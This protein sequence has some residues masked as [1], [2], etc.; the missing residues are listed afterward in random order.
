MMALDPT[1]VRLRPT[2]LSRHAPTRSESLAQ[3]AGG[4]LL[5]ASRIRKHAAEAD[6]DELHLHCVREIR[7]FQ[8]RAGRSRLPR[9][10]V[11]AA[12]YALCMV[13]DEAVLGMPWSQ[14]SNWASRSMALTFHGEASC[15]GELARFVER[16]LLQPYRYLPFLEVLYLCLS[17]GMQRGYP[18]QDPSA[19]TLVESR[20]ELLRAIGSVRG[21]L[22]EELLHREEYARPQVNW[23]L[24]WLTGSAVF[25]TLFAAAVYFGRYG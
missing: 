8:E 23:L 17:I 7:R 10:Q 13:I 1:I 22:D 19:R 14:R 2:C 6:L 21:T 5:L 12:S 9:E 16:A 24:W 4:T 20:Y 11:M 3:A 15:A 25:A 18:V